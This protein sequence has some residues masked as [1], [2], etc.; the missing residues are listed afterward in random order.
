MLNIVG[1]PYSGSS[2]NGLL[3][4]KLKPFM[5]LSSRH[6]HCHQKWD[7]TYYGKSAW[8][9]DSTLQ[10]RPNWSGFMQQVTNE[11]SSPEKSAI[12]FLPIIDLN[13][14]DETCLHSTLFSHSTSKQ[15]T[16]PNSNHNV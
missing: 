14:S 5:Q 12:S 16:T 2:Y 3:K 15:T 10:P 9:F 8:F 4:F 1:L 11:R 13:P 6:I 7:T